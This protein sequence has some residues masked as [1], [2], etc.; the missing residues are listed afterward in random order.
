MTTIR[1][2]TVLTLLCLLAGSWL[3]RA[4]G[5]SAQE[6]AAKDPASSLQAAF[7]EVRRG[8][9]HASGGP[10]L[11]AMFRPETRS[12][13]PHPPLHPAPQTTDAN[14]H[15]VSGGNILFFNLPVVAVLDVL[16]LSGV[17]DE[18]FDLDPLIALGAVA[19]PTVIARL[20]GARTLFA[21]AGSAIGFGSGSL[22]AKAFDKFG[23]FVVPALHAGVTAMLS[24]LGDR[25]R[26]RRTSR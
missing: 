23:V 21:L 20:M 11:S 24:V 2:L 22:F 18:G 10:G 1:R 8:P 9:F 26:G 17:G 3:A 5:V 4:G 14:E 19:A 13:V 15:T 6:R 12:E 16:A 7:E 25:G